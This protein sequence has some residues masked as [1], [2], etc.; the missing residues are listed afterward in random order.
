M[1][2][3][4]Q[5]VRIKRDADVYRDDELTEPIGTLPK[6]EL[7]TVVAGPFRGRYII[8]PDNTQYDRCWIRSNHFDEVD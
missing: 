7:A 3:K 4:G 6:G 8:K 1:L 2:E 5:R